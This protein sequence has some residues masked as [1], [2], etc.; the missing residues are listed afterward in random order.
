MI[1]GGLIWFLHGNRCIVMVT[2]REKPGTDGTEP[3]LLQS[4]CS[5]CPVGWRHR[6]RGQC[7]W[8]VVRG[9]VWCQD[10]P[11]FPRTRATRPSSIPGSLTADCRRLQLGRAR[12]A[13]P[14]GAPVSPWRPTGHLPGLG[15]PEGHR[16]AAGLRVSVFRLESCSGGGMNCPWLRSVGRNSHGHRAEPCLEARPS[17]VCLNIHLFH[18][19]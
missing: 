13:C 12:G 10:C 2:E 16:L 11:F 18:L 9:D 8:G 1:F 7:P 5:S 19:F 6:P 14:V 17:F 3:V 15:G 4:C